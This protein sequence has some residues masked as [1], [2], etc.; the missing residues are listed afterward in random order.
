MEHYA[1]DLGGLA[2]LLEADIP[3]RAFKAAAWENCDKVDWYP[4]VADLAVSGDLGFTAG[5]WACSLA[6]GAQIQGHYLTLWKRD[7]GRD[8]RVQFDA[9]VSNPAPAVA[10]SRLSSGDAPSGRASPPPQAAA[11]AAVGQAIID[12]QSTA[13]QDGIAAGLR[14]YARTRD[15]RFYTD[16]QAP[17][18]LADANRYFT[19]HPILGTCEEHSRMRSADSTL[20]YCGGV[21]TDAKRRSGHAYAQI[22]QYEPRVANW[23]L[24]VLLINSLSP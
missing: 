15:F 8:W 12:F 4:V 20:A 19:D 21:F 1:G 6:S 10:E 7:E 23:G 11:D 16:T 5:P 13:G 24:R 14:T 3:G 22:W 2:S 18:G 17:M 9:G